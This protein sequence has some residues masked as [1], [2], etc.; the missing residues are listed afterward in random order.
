MQH[1]RPR[2]LRK[3]DL[4]AD[5]QPVTQFAMQRLVVGSELEFADGAHEFPGEEQHL[6]HR[7]VLAER[8]ELHLVVVSDRAS[9]AD[10]ERRVP[11]LVRLPGIFRDGAEDDVDVVVAGDGF[12][13]VAIEGA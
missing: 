8:H 4:V 10:E 1:L 5:R 7:D 13:G 3:D 9:R 11:H 2:D 6:A 12:D